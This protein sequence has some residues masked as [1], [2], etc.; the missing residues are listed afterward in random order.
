MPALQVDKPQALCIYAFPQV[1]H[2]RCG[3][4]YALS[5]EGSE[6]PQKP[7]RE[8]RRV[9]SLLQTPTAWQAFGTWIMRSAPRI[10][11]VE[12]AGSAV[13]SPPFLT[14][15]GP[16]AMLHGD[17][18]VLGPEGLIRGARYAPP[19]KLSIDVHLLDEGGVVRVKPRR[20]VSDWRFSSVEVGKQ[21]QP[22]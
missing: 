3:R 11:R 2:E 18:R 19:L 6:S 5:F 17:P 8:A 12:A 22:P 9:K 13:A 21:I 4:I 7:D 20:K 16:L 1:V 10:R 14:L 15:R